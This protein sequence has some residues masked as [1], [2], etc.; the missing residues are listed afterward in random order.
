MA[1]IIGS[2]KQVIK[3]TI[4]KSQVPRVLSRFTGRRV[5]ILRYHSVQPEPELFQHSIGGGIIHS[6][7]AFDRQMR[8][9]AENFHL[10]TLQEVDS[11]LRGEGKV[12]VRAVAVTFD[13][14]FRDNYEIAAPILQRWKVPATFY[15]T[16]GLADSGAAPWFSRLR[17]AFNMTGC[18]SWRDTLAKRCWP[19]T[20]K[21]AKREAFLSAS[22]RCAVLPTEQR[23]A[24][25]DDIEQDLEVRLPADLRLMMTWEEVRAL[26]R[27]GHTIGSH[28]MQ[29]P[30]LA[31]I[32]RSRAFEELRQSKEILEKQ[33]K[34]PVDHFCYPAP[35]LNPHWNAETMAMTREV[36][37]R[38]A[39]TSVGGVLRAGDDP[40][41]LRRLAVPSEFTEFR[42]K[43]EMNLLGYAVS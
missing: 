32:D 10:V 9:V 16:V 42:W 25:L 15:V 6:A 31:H 3:T 2:A 13:D 43:L 7:A 8:F 4:I 17:F 12:P 39:A 20:E 34:S 14:G 26:H 23:D 27:A 35:I 18:K 41:C 19:L 5:A 22:E 36:G 29:H 33:I 37:Y 40:L 38:T 21:P 28:T 24:F 1:S 11:F 30:N